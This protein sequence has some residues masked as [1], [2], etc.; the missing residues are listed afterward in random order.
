MGFRDAPNCTYLYY[1]VEEVAIE[2]HHVRNTHKNIGLGSFVFLLAVFMSL[3]Y[4]L[5]S[6]LI[7]PMTMMVLH[8][9]EGREFKN[10]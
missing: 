7:R 2:K 3:K 6:E 9:R 5:I 1:H 8:T 10:S 4:E